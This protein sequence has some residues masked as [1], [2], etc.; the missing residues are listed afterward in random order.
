MKVAQQLKIFEFYPSKYS[1]DNCK[2]SDVNKFLK[3]IGEDDI[4]DINIINSTRNY[5][6]RTR[7]TC[8]VKY[9]KAIYDT[10]KGTPEREDEVDRW[11]KEQRQKIADRMNNAADQALYSLGR[12]IAIAKGEAKPL[13]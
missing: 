13:E 8:A 9:R 11:L 12:C 10:K 4:I 3:E 7:L 6:C 5:E 1:S 2:L